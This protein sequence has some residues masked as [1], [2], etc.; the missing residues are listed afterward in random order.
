MEPIVD[1]ELLRTFVTVARTGEFKKAAEIIC[2]S[3]GAIS[4][5]IKRLEEQTGSC[6]MTRNNRGIRL[7]EAGE[8][9]LSYGEQ[10]LKLSS[11]ALSALKTDDL[12]GKLNIG[13]PTDYAQDFLYHFMPVL[14]REQPNLEARIVC[15]RSRNLR[16]KVAAGELDIAIVAAETETF[17]ERLIWTER[18]IWSAPVGTRLEDISPL[19]IAL[20]EDSCIIRD[21]SLAELQ[22]CKINYRVVF[23][24][25]VMDNLATAVE[26]GY[27]I[28]LL[29]ESLLRSNNSRALPNRILN[30]YQVLRMCLISSDNMDDSTVEHLARCFR[31]SA[32]AVLK[33]DI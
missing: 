24:S 7:T 22:R 11:A 21:V 17:D 18:L 33:F 14:Q 5:Q 29:P 8:T 26:Q 30:S 6:L 32:N 4:M 25:P 23:G 19:P 16:N 31:L 1:L 13:I 12:Q 9:L 27:A 20:Y 10:L 28:S 15:D 3:Q 2:R